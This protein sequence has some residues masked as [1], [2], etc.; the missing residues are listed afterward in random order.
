[1]TDIKEDRKAVGGVHCRALT[2]KRS[3][4]GRGGVTILDGIEAEFECGRIALVTGE[5]GTGKSTLV[6]V[7]AGLLRPTGGE[8]VTG[9]GAVSRFTAPHRDRW[10]RR[11]GIV[12]QDLRLLDDLTVLENLMVSAV[13]WVVSWPEMMRVAQT[14]LDRTDLAAFGHRP[15]NRLS[16]GQRQRV[17]VARALMGDPRYLFLDEPTAFQ[18]DGHAR[19]LLALWDCCASQGTCVVVCSH[20]VRLRQAPDFHRRWVLDGGRLERLP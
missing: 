13:P 3:G 11:V 15:V 19:D 2:F 9:E 18:D 12:F 17:A 10:R 7:L 20:D 16:G 6:H 1:M 14:M 5:T 8:V 4:N